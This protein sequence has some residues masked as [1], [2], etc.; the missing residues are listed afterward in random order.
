M[1]GAILD[2]ENTKLKERKSLS[3]NYLECWVGYN[4]FEDGSEEFKTENRELIRRQW[5]SKPAEYRYV[6]QEEQTEKN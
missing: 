5:C 3:L 4:L 1:P 2:F 6:K